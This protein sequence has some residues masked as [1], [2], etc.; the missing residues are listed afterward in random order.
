MTAKQFT[1]VQTF[2]FIAPLC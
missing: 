1:N 2:L